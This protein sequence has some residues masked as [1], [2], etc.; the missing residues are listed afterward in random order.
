MARTVKGVLFAIDPQESEIVRLGS[1][2]WLLEDGHVRRIHCLE[3]LSLIERG[4]FEVLPNKLPVAVPESWLRMKELPL[5][6][7]PS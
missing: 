4:S 2:F 3:A 5:L 1:S 6:F 7:R